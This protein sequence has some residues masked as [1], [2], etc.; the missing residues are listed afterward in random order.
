[1]KKM[2]KFDLSDIKK[3]PIQNLLQPETEAKKEEGGGKQKKK[4]AGRPPK[5]AAERLSQKVTVNFTEAEFAKL[6][7]KSNQNFGITLPKLIRN[8]LKQ[9]GHI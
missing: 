9:E 6:S 5:R 2:G 7:E 1:M 3:Q 4:K 8:L